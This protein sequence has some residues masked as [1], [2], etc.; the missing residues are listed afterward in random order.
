MAAEIKRE[1][2]VDPQLVRGSGGVFNVTVGNTSIFSKHE[3]GRFPDEK[4]ILAKLRKQ[5]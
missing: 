5:G 4:E 1:F 3:Q 2:G